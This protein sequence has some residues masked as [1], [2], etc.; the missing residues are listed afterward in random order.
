MT[1]ALKPADPEPRR[2]TTAGAPTMQAIPEPRPW[3]RRKAMWAALAVLV[4]GLG[5]VLVW[6]QPQKLFMDETVNEDFPVAVAGTDRTDPDPARPGSTTSVAGAPPS[7][8]A[9]P[10]STIPSSIIP[11]SI[12]P[13]STVPFG[14]VLMGTVPMSTVPSSLAAAEPVVVARG[15]FQSI[16]HDTSGTVLLIAQPDGSHVLRFE[17]LDTS[18]GPDLQVLL[19]PSN[20]AAESYEEGSVEL[21]RLKGNQGDQNYAIPT[22]TD[23]GA[24]RSAVIWCERFSV[25]FGIADLRPL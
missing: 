13:S 23:P 6:F 1:G 19:S 4:A 10:S 11:S 8:T 12:I 14:T 24:W 3:P 7:T 2:S 5:F 9:V 25:A 15:S 22:G 17:D 21:G 16:E 18:N 20:A